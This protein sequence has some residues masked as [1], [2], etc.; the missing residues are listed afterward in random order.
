MVDQQLN[1]RPQ[2]D[3]SEVI[4][5]DYAAATPPS[6]VALAEQSTVAKELFFNPASIYRGGQLAQHYL[7]TS[8]QRLATI[9]ATKPE[10]IIFTAGATEANNLA[11]GGVRAA[12]KGKI[13]C[14]ATDHSSITTLADIKLPVKPQTGYLDLAALATLDDEV[15]LLSLA[16]V[17]NEVG[18]CQPLAKIRRQIN[19]VR[20]ERH[21]RG[22]S[23]P[24]WLH[25]DGSQMLWSFNVQPQSL[26]ADLLT[27]NGAK[28]YGPK[29]TGLL[30]VAKQVIIRPLL[31]G[32]DQERGL[33]PGTEDIAAIGGFK[34][35]LVDFLA[36]K[37]K[38]ASNLIELQQWFE[39]Q[40]RRLGCLVLLANSRRSPHIST[41]L[42]TTKD[43]ER[44]ALNLSHRGIYV[45]LGAACQV[46]QD[47]PEN[48]QLLAYGL[49]TSQINSSLRFSFGSLT[50]IDQLKVTIGA[51]KELI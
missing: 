17:N 39:D 11:L 29:K 15:V 16:A 41:C 32:G 30:F 35:A 46:N 13:A 37:D 9:L 31:K 26:G 51:L 27:L 22:V 33:R 36:N 19:L 28:V 6:Q 43:A 23:T 1:H 34:V 18:I 45:G 8:R 24:L 4:Y 50:T 42:M 2:P 38:Q 47:Q 25:V 5:L 7:T 21:K 20:S 44:L 48:H 14:L 12:T 40:I 3:F 10:R 49:T